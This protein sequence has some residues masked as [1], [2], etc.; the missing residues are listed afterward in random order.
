MF[1]GPLFDISSPPE[2]IKWPVTGSSRNRNQDVQQ[3]VC[4]ISDYLGNHMPQIIGAFTNEPRHNL[5]AKIS[6]FRLTF[7]AAAARALLRTDPPDCA[8]RNVTST[9]FEKKQLGL[10]I[11]HYSRRWVE[12]F[13]N[14]TCVFG[15]LG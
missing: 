7:K 2:G 9:D 4:A 3:T 14:S 10:R 11:L 15:H 5:T 13:T 8:P 12:E 1:E 6:A